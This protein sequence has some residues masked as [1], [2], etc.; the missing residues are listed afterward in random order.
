[1]A[2]HRTAAMPGTAQ[3]LPMRQVMSRFAT[4]VAV[5]GVGGEHIHGMTANAFTS[6]SLAP[7]LV[8]CCVAHTAVMHKAITSTGRFAISVL[9]AG[10]RDLAGYFAD[11]NRPLG[12]A[13]FADV[14]WTPGEHTGAPI[15]DNALAW[16]ECDLE[17]TVDCGDHAV[18]VGA[19][20]AA[21]CGESRDSLV[22][23]NGQFHSIATPPP[24]VPTAGAGST[25]SVPP[26]G[27]DG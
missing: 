5:I 25:R 6:V 11:R 19:V 15:I 4:G 23:Y 20:L 9:D 14:P 24:A 21:G 7:P 17:R 16:L 22:F 12:P 1:M 2:A 26:S 8:L 27:A 13:Q 10:Q 18:F 3:P